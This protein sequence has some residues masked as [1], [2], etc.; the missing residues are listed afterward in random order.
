MG[1]AL[2]AAAWGLCGAASDWLWRCI[3]PARPHCW[4]LVLLS[5]NSVCS[6]ADNDTFKVYQ[7]T[8]PPADVSGDNHMQA[9]LLGAI[10]IP[11]G[12]IAGI[13]LYGLSALAFDRDQNLLYAL[14]DGGALFHFRPQ[15]SAGKLT[16]VEPIAAYRLSDRNAKPLYADFADAE[17]MDARYS[18]NGE[19]GDTVLTLSFEREHR[20]ND[21]LPNGRWLKEYPLPSV[22]QQKHRYV[23]ANRS[24]EAIT[25]LHSATDVFVVAP[26]LPLRTHGERRLR[27]FASSGR[28][29]VY[30]LSQH[31]HTAVVAMESLSDGSLLVLERGYSKLFLVLTAALRRTSP[32]GDDR[33]LSASTVVEFSTQNGWRIDNMEGLAR[34]YRDHW[35]V[36]SDDNNRRFQK[37]L[38]LYLRLPGT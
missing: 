23:T 26:E 16:S 33:M 4:V 28:V 22:L 11:A 30:P 9:Q 24:L 27:I 29:W 2:H 13:P 21:Y 10:E 8:L 14:S 25:W 34:H 17:G 32:L 37:T 38:L 18:D 1:M 12:V 31:P 36:I 6:V 3:K 20:V 19:S 5:T 15:F 7:H 35:F